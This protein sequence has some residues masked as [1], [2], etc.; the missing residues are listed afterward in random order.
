M[1]NSQI[2]DPILAE[3]V[4]KL[5]KEMIN[6]P[7]G[8]T[9]EDYLNRTSL[10]IVEEERNHVEKS[11]SEAETEEE[12][13][14]REK[15]NQAPAGPRVFSIRD[16]PAE[17]SKT[18]N[19]AGKP[20]LTQITDFIRIGEKILMFGAKKKWKQFPATT[21]II[22]RKPYIRSGIECSYDFDVGFGDIHQLM[23][24]LE[25]IETEINALKK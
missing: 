5:Q 13:E 8:Q 23:S 11:V 19:P 15:E 10:R 17:K 6:K 9:E 22:L 20:V 25:T 14:E 1:P 2:K 7:K 24:A 18:M 3:Q 21:T 16:N 12:E 4:S